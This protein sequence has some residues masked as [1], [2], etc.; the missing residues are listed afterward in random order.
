MNAEVMFSSRTPEWATP[1]DLFD[2]LDKI[3]HFDLDPAATPENA[4]CIRYF[5]TE[6]DGLS[7]NWGAHR[8]FAI[9][10]TG[11]K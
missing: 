3:H 6:D 7:Q 4:K 9:P 8:C 1:Q 2:A 10:P 11:A 5:T